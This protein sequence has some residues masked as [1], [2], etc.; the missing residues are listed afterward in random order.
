MTTS[1]ALAQRIHAKRRILERFGVVI[2]RKDLQEIALLIRNGKAQFSC[3]ISHRLTRWVVPVFYKLPPMVV[4]YD[5]RRNQVVT[6]MPF[7]G[8]K[9][10]RHGWKHGNE[11]NS[12]GQVSLVREG[13]SLH[14]D[15]SGKADARGL[16]GQNDHA[17]E[18]GRVDRT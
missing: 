4:I 14:P 3:R 1:K 18:A 8:S 13:N 6:V 9:E 15:A 7:K 11:E 2:N 5:S 16:A 10:Q 17:V 12:E